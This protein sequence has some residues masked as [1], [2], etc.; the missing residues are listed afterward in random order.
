MKFVNPYLKKFIERHADLLAGCDFDQLYRD[1]QNTVSMNWESIGEFT[2][3]LLE[4]EINPLDYLEEVPAAYLFQGQDE[5]SAFPPSK[6]ILP[7]NIKIICKLAFARCSQ[8]KEIVLPEGLD[9]IGS[10]AFQYSGLE[11]IN[12]PNSL[13][14]L[15]EAAFKGCQSLTHINIPTSLSG[16]ED[17]TFAGS[18]L[19]EIEF[20]E[21][22]R[23]I[24]SYAFQKCYQLRKVKLPKS[25]QAIYDSAFWECS[26]LTVEFAGTKEQW[27]EVERETSSFP[28][29]QKIKCSDGEIGY[30][31]A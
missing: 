23:F 30:Y 8:L 28:R 22:F 5:K 6:L 31:Y 2:R 10:E 9:F 25:L 18:G 27:Q 12:L 20:P 4:A 7:S 1:L 16:L 3:M 19:E 11:K 24:G 26:D 15:R 13:T 17:E 14:R 21:G 29:D